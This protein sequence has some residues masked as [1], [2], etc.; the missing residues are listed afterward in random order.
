M[1]FLWKKGVGVKDD[2]IEGHGTFQDVPNFEVFELGMNFLSIPVTHE[3]RAAEV[4]KTSQ[5]VLETP[6]NAG[7]RTLDPTK[8]P[9]GQ[10]VAISNSNPCKFRFDTIFYNPTQFDG[11]AS[12]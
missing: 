12:P 6:N 11:L 1:D 4:V 5:E 7:K 8:H 10:A 2:K 3:I 9:P